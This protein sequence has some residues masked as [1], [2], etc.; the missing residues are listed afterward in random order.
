MADLILVVLYSSTSGMLE[1][2]H[3]M[4]SSVKSIVRVKFSDAF[5]TSLFSFSPYNRLISLYVDTKSL[6]ISVC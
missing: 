4:D 1:E 3:I 2:L 5:W 6:L